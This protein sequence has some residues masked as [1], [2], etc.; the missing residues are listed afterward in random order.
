MSGYQNLCKMDVN[1]AN[2]QRHSHIIDI[3]S[4]SSKK[5]TSAHWEN[6]KKRKSASSNIFFPN[7]LKHLT[8]V[9]VRGYAIKKY[10]N[11]EWVFLQRFKKKR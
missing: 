3:Y 6:A 4:P 10:Q 1:V 8:N 5:S 11:L 2:S 7:C 9:E